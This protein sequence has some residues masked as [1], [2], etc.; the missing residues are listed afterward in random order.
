MVRTGIGTE[1]EA[2]GGQTALSHIRPAAASP[3]AS[4]VASVVGTASRLFSEVQDELEIGQIAPEQNFPSVDLG[5]H[6]V[7]GDPLGVVQ[8]IGVLELQG[9]PFQYP[10]EIFI[11]FLM[12]RQ[13]FLI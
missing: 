10:P 1:P 11:S 12:Q 7:G 4:C 8:C 9:K 5:N 3:P 13:S 6:V 2:L